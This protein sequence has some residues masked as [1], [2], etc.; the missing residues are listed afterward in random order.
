MIGRMIDRLT[1]GEMAEISGLPL[2]VV[3]ERLKEIKPDLSGKWEVEPGFLSPSSE[4]SCDGLFTLKG[5]CERYKVGESTMRKRLQGVQPTYRL[6]RSYRSLYKMTPALQMSVDVPLA[7]TAHHKEPGDEEKGFLK[8]CDKSVSDM[9]EEE[10]EKRKW[11][12][13]RGVLLND[14]G[15]V[16]TSGKIETVSCCGVFINGIMGQMKN[17]RLDD[18]RTTMAD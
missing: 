7:R 14:A 4:S 12:G 13:K 1:A 6:R 11:V 5:L 9:M 3:Q 2:E 15:K 17:L 8:S 16:V 10:K 18:G